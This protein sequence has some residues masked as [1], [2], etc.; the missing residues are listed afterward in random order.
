MARIRR[1]GLFGSRFAIITP[2]LRLHMVDEAAC[3]G[4]ICVM[5]SKASAN[6]EGFLFQISNE[7]RLALGVRRTGVLWA[8]SVIIQKFY[9]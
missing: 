8:V 9:R 7:T 1:R 6:W 3:P 2:P 5:C 4:M